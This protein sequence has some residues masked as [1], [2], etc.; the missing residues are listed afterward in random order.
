[1]PK[2]ELDDALLVGGA[3]IVATA[4]FAMAGWAVAALTVGLFSIY[5]AMRKPA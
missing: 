4:L 5:L 2:I 3:A 1:M